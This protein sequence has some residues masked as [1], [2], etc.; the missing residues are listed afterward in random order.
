MR[1][2]ISIIYVAFIAASLLLARFASLEF[3]LL[4]AAFAIPLI[5]NLMPQFESVSD[6]LIGRMFFPLL[7]GTFFVLFYHAFPTL[8][9][10]SSTDLT[11]LG[12]RADLSG[13]IE[14][15]S[16]EV[17]GIFVNAITVL[18]A[19]T[20][21]FLLLKGL[22]DLDELK[23]ILHSEANEIHS[24]VDFSMYFQDDSAN[25]ENVSYIIRLYGLL[26]RYIENFLETAK[27]SS[28]GKGYA[29]SEENEAVISECIVVVSRLRS[30]DKNDEFALQELMRSVR[31]L[32][33]LRARRITSIEKKMSPY[34]L[35]TI[36]FMSIA[37]VLSFFS[38]AKGVFSIEYVYVFLLPA[39]YCA[40]FMTLL[41]LSQPFNGYW[42]IKL[43]AVQSARTRLQK[44]LGGAESAA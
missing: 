36:L 13:G 37:M 39:F 20:V 40:I 24:I 4:L 27:R 44:R 1:W 16:L 8:I 12:V 19:I 10:G 17:S 35:T 43:E 23:S 25:E 15:V 22:N 9:S 41:D 28:K 26:S 31:S 18:Y 38:S 5:V 11:R 7:V 2:A 30:G 42:S 21:A 29:Y 3:W 34:L 33:S 14:L 32:G 6:A